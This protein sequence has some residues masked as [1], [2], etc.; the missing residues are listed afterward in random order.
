[1]AIMC[2]C[3]A[4]S[5][6]EIVIVRTKPEAPDYLTLSDTPAENPYF[7]PTQER[8][9]SGGDCMTKYSDA[10]KPSANADPFALSTQSEKLREDDSSTPH[11]PGGYIELFVT[12]VKQ[13]PEDKVG[14][15]LTKCLGET[16]VVNAV[17]EGLIQNW[18]LAS[19]DGQVIIGDLLYQVNN[20]K[21]DAD[22]LLER[23]KEDNQLDM[24]FVRPI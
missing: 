16:L 21:G 19:K 9:L 17:K 11:K 24:M 5:Q 4:E 14:M 23:I 2:C 20:V 15:A 7:M 13:R 12:V 18:N 8:A 6:T 1:M 10:E 22:K 3:G